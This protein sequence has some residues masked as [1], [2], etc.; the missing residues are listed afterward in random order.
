MSSRSSR[1]GGRWPWQVCGQ[2][3]SETVVVAQVSGTGSQRV[4]RVFSFLPKWER[5]PPACL[6]VLL[7]GLPGAGISTCAQAGARAAQ[8]GWRMPFWVLPRGKLENL[9]EPVAAGPK[10]PLSSLWPL[11]P[12]PQLPAQ[13]PRSPRSNGKA[14]EPSSSSRSHCP[15]PC[16]L[17]GMAPCLRRL[18]PMGTQPE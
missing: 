7:P 10:K 17:G 13:H 2:G 6:S 4:S 8:P 3:F 14:E 16:A 15:L 11:P 12:Q 18:T 5:R 9:H 1:P